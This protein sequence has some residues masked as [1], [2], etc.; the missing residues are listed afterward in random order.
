MTRRAGGRRRRFSAWALAAVLGLAGLARLGGLAVGLLGSGSTSGAPPAVAAAGTVPPPAA[1]QPAAAQP[2]AAQPATAP[3]AAEPEPTRRRRFFVWV[4]ATVLGLAG[5]GVLAVGL[6]GPGGA[7]GPP[8]PAVAAG[9]IPPAASARPAAGP[10]P[11]PGVAPSAAPL[12]LAASAPVSLQIPKIGV[13]S[14]L[15]PLGLNPDDTIQVPTD[16]ATAG[17]YTQAP[18]PGQTG[19]AVI[20]GHIDSYR[21]PAVFYRLGQLRPGDTT[22]V[23]RADGTVARFAVD[24]V[25]DYPKDH[26]PTPLVYGPVDYPGLRLITCGGAFDHHTRQYLDNIVVYAHLVPSGPPRSPPVPRSSPGT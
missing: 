1:A 12:V 13:A 26:F 4:L 5:M 2:A 9:T 3:P 25:R 8:R 10:I 16:F 21:G 19:P 23:A 20:L 14:D 24:A 11:A 17:W 7:P 22:D 15:V 6:A 18:T